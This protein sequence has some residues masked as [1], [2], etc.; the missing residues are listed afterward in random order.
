MNRRG[1]A[2]PSPPRCARGDAGPCGPAGPPRC[3]SPTPWIGTADVHRRPAPRGVTA[4]NS[5]RWRWAESNADSVARSS[6]SPMCWLNHAYLPSA[7][8]I[9]FFRSA[10]TARVGGTATGRAIGSGAYPRERRIGSSTASC[11]LSSPPTATTRI[12]ESSHGT[13]IA[14]SCINQPSARCESRSSASSSVK[15]IGSPARFPEVITRIDG[16]GSSPARPNNRV[17]SG[18]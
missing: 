4:V 6:M 2:R 5:C 15:Q 14:R 12:T 17:C 11:G 1:R 8:A 18:A 3:G 7:T 9:V 13:R 10:P 16:P